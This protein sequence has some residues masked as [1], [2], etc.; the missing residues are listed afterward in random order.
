MIRAGTLGVA[1]HTIRRRHIGCLGLYVKQIR[2]ALCL[3]AG[4]HEVDE[5]VLAE[6]HWTLINADKETVS[7]VQQTYGLTKEAAR[8]A[9][10]AFNHMSYLIAFRKP[11]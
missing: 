8:K 10:L 7:L 2:C 3:N 6:I 4:G 1:R 11:L 9:K 5:D